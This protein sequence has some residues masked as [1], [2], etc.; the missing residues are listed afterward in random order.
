[1]QL[2]YINPYYSKNKFRSFSIYGEFVDPI[3][4]RTQSDIDILIYLLKKGYNQFSDY[5]KSI[6]LSDL[7]GALNASDMNRIENN[8]KILSKS[9]G[10]DAE[11][12]IWD[13]IDIPQAQ[14]FERIRNN[15]AEI[16]QSIVTLSINTPD[17]PNLPMNTYQKINAI[18]KIIFDVYNILKA[19][20]YYY[21]SSEDVELYCGEEGI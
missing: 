20:F 5:E 18:E 17:V 7:K 9:V 3:F 11:T 21:C 2:D 14:D 6:W 8:I 15:L 10:V 1:M 13:E 16:R 4:D 12:K 19:N